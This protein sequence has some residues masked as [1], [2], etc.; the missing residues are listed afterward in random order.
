ML[1]RTIAIFTCLTLLAACDQPTT[2]VEAPPLQETVADLSTASPVTDLER[3][4][5]NIVE[6]S[7]DEYGGREPM[8][9]G[10]KL[11]LDFIESRFQEMGLQPMFGDSYLQPVEL[12]SIEA[13]PATAKMTFH[14]EDS[15]RLVTHGSEMVIGTQRVVPE[16]TVENSDVVFVGYGIVAPEYGWNDYADVDVTGKTVLILVNDPGFATKDPAVFKGNA[17]T[18]YGRWTYKY[19]EAARQGAAAA[20]V[21]HDTA[22]ASYG[23]DVVRNS[24]TGPRFSLAAPDDN[25]SRSPIESWILRSVAEEL[26]E[27]AG[28]DYATLTQQALSP[29]FKAVELGSKMDAT[30]QNKVNRNQSYNVG[31]LLP[32]SARPEELFIYTAHWDHIGTDL[33]VEDGVDGIFNGAV[34][35]ASGIA[36]LLELASSFTA[37]PRAPERSVGFLA[38]TAEESGL[39]GSKQYAAHPPIPMSKTVGG[40]NM[41]SM[42]VYGPT[43]DVVVV[44]F[45]SSELE[46]ILAAKAADQGRIVKPEIH[47]ERGGYYRSDHFNFAKK[48]VP[49]LYAEAGSDHRELGPGYI[50]AKSQEYLKNRYHTAL[51]EVGDDWDLRGLAQ[52]IELWFNIG[53]EVAD[54]D[55]WPNW[56]EGNEF[57]AIRDNSL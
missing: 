15:D 37:L 40:I 1:T 48:G 52:D 33:T 32:G 57:K 8:S 4:M 38:V 18:Y 55:V 47:P 35:N 41:D 9:E 24:W 51:D 44:G 39:L 25:M 34:D 26:V 23:W 45:G 19:E 46:D 5:A 13:D 3:I 50:E 17:M 2:P 36:A 30:V 29:E 53:L 21:I 56:Y 10:E 16:S 43:N 22:P 54:S 42:H 12:V 11:T 49:M 31:A 7:S 27:D 14:L 6:L 28:L 20:L